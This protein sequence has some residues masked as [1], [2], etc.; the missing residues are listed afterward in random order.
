MII[1]GV[2]YGR[3]RIGLAVSD[4]L[5]IA[6]HGLPTVDCSDEEQ[7][8]WRVADAASAR[9][10]DLIV[11]GMPT[12]MDGSTGAQAREVK[13]FARRLADATGKPV[14][15]VDERLSTYE[16]EDVLKQMGIKAKDWPKYID[17]LSAK[18]ILTRYLEKQSRRASASAPPEQGDES[19]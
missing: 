7:A 11:I 17:Q 1:L 16:A 5:G 6:A 10:V 9:A 4:P 8:I 14:E 18:I 13:R 2:D 15:P 19:C 3:R 12:N